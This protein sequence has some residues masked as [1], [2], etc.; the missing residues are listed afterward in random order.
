[1]GVTLSCTFPD[2]VLNR[3]FG[4]AVLKEMQTDRLCFHM[5][6]R[7]QNLSRMTV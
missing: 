2:Y 7:K 1:M 5:I 6:F 3:R 4:Q